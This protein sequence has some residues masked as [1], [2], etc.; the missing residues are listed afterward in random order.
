MM[1]PTRTPGSDSVS[2][3]SYD[4]AIF[5]Q[6]GFT[7]P[8]CTAKCPKSCSQ[9]YCSALGY[10]LATPMRVPGSDASSAQPND[11]AVWCKDGFFG[12]TCSS[13]CPLNCLQT[14]CGIS[15]NCMATR[16]RTPESDSGS[17]DFY[18][19]AS[20]CQD[21]WYG[22]TCANRCPRFCIQSYCSS[23]GYC[24]AS[25]TRNPGSDASSSDPY[26]PA[27]WCLDGYSGSDCSKFCPINCAQPYCSSNGYCMASRTRTPGSD[28][29]SADPK[30][31]A[32]FCKDGFYGSTCSSPCPKTCPEPYCA[33][34]GQCLSRPESD[35]VSE[36]F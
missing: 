15:G 3:Q 12:S 29:G 25:P 20:Y 27:T 10:C 5:C 22:A 13:E 26:D 2:A 24:M 34:S 33:V 14:Y 7:G 6:D 28:N 21:G 30:A 8:S 31:R 17:S 32:V 23:G 18:D 36:R 1:T 9:A 19:R 16:T 4:R 11:P 35:A